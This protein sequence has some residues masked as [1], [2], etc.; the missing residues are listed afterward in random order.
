MW[1]CDGLLGS[2][3]QHLPFEEH[4]FCSGLV[5]IIFLSWQWIYFVKV[6]ALYFFFSPLLFFFP[7]SWLQILQ[8][9]SPT[10]CLRGKVRKAM[11]LCMRVQGC[12]GVNQA[13]SKGS[14]HCWPLALFIL[15]KRKY[16]KL[17]QS[18]FRLG[19]GKNLFWKDYQTLEQ[20]AQGNGRVTISGGI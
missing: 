2:H 10:C 5:C 6:A 12:Y 3:L 19:S 17:C 18:R 11:K 20:A 14:H 7:L 15:G 8:P 4:K 13:F 1:W 16:F 9:T